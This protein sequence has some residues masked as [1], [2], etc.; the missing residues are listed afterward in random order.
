[1]VCL[2]YLWDHLKWDDTHHKFTP[3]SL[4]LA[5][6]RHSVL[7]T[8]QKH[9]TIS[10]HLLS[11]CFPWKSI[12]VTSIRATPLGSTSSY[13][14]QASLKTFHPF[15]QEKQTLCANFCSWNI[16]V[17]TRRMKDC[18]NNFRAWLKGLP[19]SVQKKREIPKWEKLCFSAIT[20]KLL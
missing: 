8:K 19:Q 1:M 2:G 10:Q 11:V 7:N 14:M 4:Q 20:T 5:Q 17:V 9:I 12:Y 3:F 6:C 16:F 15:H 18:H 13:D